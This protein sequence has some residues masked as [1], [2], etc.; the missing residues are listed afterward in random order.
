MNRP[1][2][3][4]YLILDCVKKY[5]EENEES[6]TL[7][8]LCEMSGINTISTVHVHLKNLEKLGYVEIKPRIKRGIVLKD[9][10]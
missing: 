2:F 8:E 9:I 10:K 6:P 7:N 3:I 5:I 1:T 4:Q